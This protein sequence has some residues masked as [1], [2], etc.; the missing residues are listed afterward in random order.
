[1]VNI[2]WPESDNLIITIDPDTLVADIVGVQDWYGEETIIFTASDL[3]GASTPLPVTF[4]V[5]NVEDNPIVLKPIGE[6]V[7]DEDT[8]KDLSMTEYFMDP[9]GD[10]LTFTLSSNL[11]V[12]YTVDSTTWVMT[13]T[14]EPDWFGFREIWVTAVDTTGRTAQ[15]RFIFIV[16]GVPDA[17]EIVSVSPP[18]QQVEVREESSQSFVVLNVSDPEFSILIYTWYLDGKLVGPS[19]F[20]NYKPSYMDQGAHEL[21]VVVTDEEGESDEFTW[22]VVVNDV[23]RPPEGGVA[24]PANN[25]KFFSNEKIPFVALYYDLDGD[26]LSYQWFIDGKLQASEFS[27]DKKLDEGKHQVR[28]AVQSG[29]FTVEKFL[30]VTVE[31]AETPGFEA[32]LVFT[33]LVVTFIAAA[34]WR[35]RRI[36]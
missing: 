1:V 4:I 24:S 15:E 36:E 25:A 27:F 10:D 22:N 21:R 14:P 7:I 20:Y 16:E 11:N 31:Q 17:P 18:S 28:L 29:D 19:N 23:P 12:D 26:E 9:D 3:M 13:L 35:R 5:E 33:G 6:S 30:N 8:T 34:A 2:T 32:P